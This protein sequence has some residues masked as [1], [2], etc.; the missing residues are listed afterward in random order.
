MTARRSPFAIAFVA[1]VTALA[2]L[3]GC[4]EDVS[5][6]TGGALEAG[7]PG[8]ADA[9][10]LV[11][12]APADDA[13]LVLDARDDGARTN[14]CA[15]ESDASTACRSNGST[16]RAT[17]DCCSGRCEDGYCLKLGTCSAPG[18]PC[19]SRSGCCS[20]RCEPTGRNGALACGQYCQADGARC[21]EPSD[22]CS[23]A[24]ND[25][26]CG[27]ALCDVLGSPCDHDASCCSDRCENGRC[28]EDLVTC[29]P[30]GEACGGDA[31]A[32]AIGPMGPGAP[33][34][35]CCS[36]FC[37]ART[38][39]CDLGP[40]YCR[41]PSAPCDVDGECCRGQCLRNADGVY[42][43][44]APCIPDGQDCNSNGDCCTG[45]CG[46]PLSQCG[47]AASIC[48]VPLSP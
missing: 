4:G 3:A 46:G 11:D 5:F 14:P 26:L 40:G 22:C 38:S 18:T 31:G 9:A 7:A 24:C 10:S 43:C 19:D 47:V 25:G 36:G 27:G 20:E 29:L 1:A 35:R 32:M 48:P 13:P 42:A 34:L 2:A 28:A 21:D 44:T 15:V 33:A 39:R 6:T 8:P 30:T 17:K 16:C 45:V 23:L 37:D 12:A 41:E